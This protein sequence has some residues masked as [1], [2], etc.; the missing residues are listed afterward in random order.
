MPVFRKIVFLVRFTKMKP[1]SIR[2]RIAALISALFLLQAPGLFAAPGDLDTTFAG[3]GMLRVGFGHSPD[4]ARAV[5][6]TPD[7]KIL[8]AGNSESQT[9]I[10]ARFGT[11]NVLDTTFGENG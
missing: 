1:N 2:L 8:M 9:A 10:L 6:Q 7:G 11:N 4:E 5:A 3:T